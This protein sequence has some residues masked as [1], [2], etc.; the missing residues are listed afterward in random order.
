MQQ[1]D[2][3]SSQRRKRIEEDQGEKL[4]EHISTVIRSYRIS[5]EPL[6]QKEL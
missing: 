4:V 2:T 3:E 5:Q 1:S 6:V